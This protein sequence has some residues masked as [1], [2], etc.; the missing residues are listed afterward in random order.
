MHEVRMRLLQDVPCRERPFLKLSALNTDHN[1]LIMASRIFAL[2]IWAAVAA[3]L[4]FWGLRWLAPPTGVPA[5]TQS[6]SLDS[7]AQGDM[8]RLLNGPTKASKS[9]PV[10]TAASELNARIKLIGVMAPRAGSTNGIALLSID[11]KPARAIR[12]GDVVDGAL[13]LKSLSH[14]SVDIGLV[15]GPVAVTLDLPLLPPPSMGS[16]PAVAGL[17]RPAPKVSIEQSMPNTLP[18]APPATTPKGTKGRL[19]GPE[20]G[21][22]RP[23][24]APDNTGAND[25]DHPSGPPA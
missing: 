11:G 23:G 6:V 21:A 25:D 22:M 8:R 13:V 24:K 17:N 3:S 16:L 19:G 4:A 7:S 15:D 10:M 20:G 5:M 2:L 12:L 14:R 1:G 9:A 18:G